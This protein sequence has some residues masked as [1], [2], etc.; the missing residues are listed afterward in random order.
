MSPELDK[1]ADE[2][3]ALKPDGFAAARDEQVREARAGGHKELARE[4]AAL[5]RPTQSAWL[6]NRLWRDQHEVM[7]QLFEL[8][9]ELSR[10]QARASGDQ[11]RMLTTQ[12]RAIESALMGRARELA[13]EAAMNLSPEMERE[14]QETLSAALAQ[15]AAADEVRGGRLVKPIE[16]AGFGML[17]TMAPAP[18]RQDEATQ[19]RAPTPLREP[20]V[21][22]RKEREARRARERVDAARAAALQ[23]GAAVEAAKRALDEQVKEADAVQQR[24]DDLRREIEGLRKK[25]ADL[26]QEVTR[27]DAAIGKATRQVDQAHKEHAIAVNDLEEAEQELKELKA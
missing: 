21:D 24:L 17:P 6:V 2:L 14:V 8:S 18:R 19:V 23:A 25:E 20:Q 3:Y 10:A 27:H 7:E 11:L 9:D 1:I 22:D 15:P 4:L 16:Y 26:E 13:Q 5:R 12:R